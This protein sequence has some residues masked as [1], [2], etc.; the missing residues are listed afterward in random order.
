MC[1]PD[2]DPFPIR[3]PVLNLRGKKAHGLCKGGEGKGVEKAE[4]RTPVVTLRV[5]QQH[6]E[7]STATV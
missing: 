6:R 3:S 1:C 4:R 5:I 7:S 2:V